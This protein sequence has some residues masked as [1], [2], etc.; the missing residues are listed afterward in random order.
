MVLLTNHFSSITNP[1]EFAGMIHP[2]EIGEQVVKSSVIYPPQN[3]NID[4]YKELKLPSGLV[5]K[6]EFNPNEITSELITEGPIQERNKSILNL[7]NNYLSKFIQ[8][9]MKKNMGNE[10]DRIYFMYFLLNSSNFFDT[11]INNL[12]LHEVK[13]LLGNSCDKIILGIGDKKCDSIFFGTKPRDFAKNMK[14]EYEKLNSIS[15]ELKNKIGFV[16]VTNQEESTGKRR[17][18]KRKSK[19]KSKRKFSSKKRKS[20]KKSRKKRS[21]LKRR[22][23]K[24]KRRRYRKKSLKKKK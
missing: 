20:K 17:S 12:K 5:L 24:S 22:F 4:K 2:L 8:D 7:R 11:D 10:L 14:K 9:Y 1:Y 15:Q 21:T 13:E 19:K 6:A 16:D 3:I 23:S 18:G